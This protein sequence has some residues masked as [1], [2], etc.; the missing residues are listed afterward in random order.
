MFFENCIKAFVRLNRP[1]GSLSILRACLPKSSENWKRSTERTLSAHEREL[2]QIN[3]LLIGRTLKYL[4]PGIE[5][6]KIPAAKLFEMGLPKD[7]PD[8]D[9]FW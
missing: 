6:K 3:R 9:D 1:F 5:K 8:P 4:F 2:N 7:E